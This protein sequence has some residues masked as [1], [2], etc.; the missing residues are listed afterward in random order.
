MRH[1][2]KT[3]VWNWMFEGDTAAIKKSSEKIE[4]RQGFLTF[5]LK[6]VYPT[7]NPN[8]IELGESISIMFNDYDDMSN[9]GS[10]LV[11]TKNEEFINAL[12]TEYLIIKTGRRDLEDLLCSISAIPSKITRI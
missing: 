3:A 5:I 1:F 11:V 2:N 12:Y 7:T 6:V 10:E 4:N 9:L 8:L